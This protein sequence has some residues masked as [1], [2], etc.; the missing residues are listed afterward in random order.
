MEVS[1]VSNG[2][3]L[4]TY[5]N[6]FE[7]TDFGYSIFGGSYTTGSGNVGDK[8]VAGH[9]AIIASNNATVDLSKAI[10][11]APEAIKIDGGTLKLNASKLNFSKYGINVTGQNLDLS[12]FSCNEFVPDGTITTAPV[13]AL[14]IAPN[15]SLGTDI[16]GDGVGAH[17][18]P[19]GNIWPV[20]NN[21]G[22]FTQTSN[23]NG[24]NSPSNW[25][26]VFNEGSSSVTLWPY[27]NEYYGNV[28]PLSGYGAVTPNQFS[29]KKY[30]TTG[31]PPP[32]RNDVTQVC[33]TLL[34]NPFGPFRFAAPISS[35]NPTGIIEQSNETFIRD[36]FP[37]PG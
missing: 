21:S 37:N 24:W 27:S 1:V 26:S 17:P 19:D 5:D 11:T 12:S 28:Y 20:G 18:S 31:T 6:D 10:L 34:T 14:R 35:N 30:A 4:N 22:T 33:S 2:S 29:P 16:G 8:I 7:G 9:Q 25:Y 15:G 36:C 23:A 32:T 3:I 13:A